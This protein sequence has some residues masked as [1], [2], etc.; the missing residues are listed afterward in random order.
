MVLFTGGDLLEDMP[1]EE[2]LDGS[3]DLQE[4]V[5]KCN[6][7]YHVFNNKLKDQTQ[8]TELFQKI[9]NIVQK[10]GGSHYTN[11]MFQ[12][13]ERALEEEK[14]RILREKEEKIRKEK[15]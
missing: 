13:A 1:I 9:R 6:N 14:Q 4:L 2:F 5:A 8:V 10:N 7:Q 3:G 11:E 12:E 15:S